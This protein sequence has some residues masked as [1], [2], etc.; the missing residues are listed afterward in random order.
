MPLVTLGRPHFRSTCPHAS[1]RETVSFEDGLP[2]NTLE[3]VAALAATAH[4]SVG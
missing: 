1:L 4:P 2:D 3:L